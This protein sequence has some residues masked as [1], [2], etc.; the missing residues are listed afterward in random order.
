M[1]EFVLGGLLFLVCLYILSKMEIW[2]R[3]FDYTVDR[4][5]KSLYH[6]Q[7]GTLKYLAHTF[8]VMGSYGLGALCMIPACSDTIDFWWQLASLVAGFSIFKMST[9]Y[10]EM[11]YSE[12]I[13]EFKIKL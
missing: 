6:K 5:E 3:Y 13:A 8:A 10:F 4:L 9:D 2:M 1:T 11:S 7:P 12:S